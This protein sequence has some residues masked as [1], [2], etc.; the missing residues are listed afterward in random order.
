MSADEQSNDS[1]KLQSTT[2]DGS[3]TFSAVVKKLA[4][5]INYLSLDN[6]QITNEQTQALHKVWLSKSERVAIENSW[7]RATKSNAREQVG[8]Q[9][10][11]RIL[12][13]RPEMKHLF[14]LQKIP[15]GRLKYDPRFRRHA[16]VFTKSFDYIVKN[17]AYKEK[18]E[19]HF[20]ALGER[21]TTFQG[22]GFNPEYWDT[23][24]D[25]M[26]QTVSLWGRD[27]NHKTE[28]A[29]HM[30][31][32][33]VLQNMKIGFDRANSRH[34]RRARHVRRIIISPTQH[35]Q[36][37]GQTTDPIQF[38]K[39]FCLQQKKRKQTSP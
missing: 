30:L 1:S 23:F 12:S 21:H 7:N 10:F 36:A 24:N 20:Q 14:D 39:Q 38:Y 4:T 18:L 33:F 31:V 15:E 35:D 17:I 37:H 6:E 13:A 27:K 3:S 8:I 25:C 16:I 2:D 11:G 28:N 19:Q 29:W 34:P 32:S 9:L 5:N 22:R 26:K